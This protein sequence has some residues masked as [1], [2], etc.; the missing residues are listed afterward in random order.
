MSG[1]RWPT[2][3]KL[4]GGVYSVASCP[5]D[6]GNRFSRHLSMKYRTDPGR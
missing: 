6:T 5:Q 2:P 4:L 3:L 1:E